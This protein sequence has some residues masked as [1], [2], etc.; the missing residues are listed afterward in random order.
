MTVTAS[1]KL[2]FTTIVS[3][4]PNKPSSTAALTAVRVGPVTSITSVFH[5]APVNEIW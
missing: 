5:T 4:M 1:L 2:T 3:P